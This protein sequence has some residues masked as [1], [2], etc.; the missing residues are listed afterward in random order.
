MY[1]ENK[2][3]DIDGYEARIGWVSFS[4][5]GR[6]VYYRG[7]HLKRIRRGGVFGNYR[8]SE[9]EDEYWVSGVKQRG[10]NAHRFE[11]KQIHIDKDA[12]LAY[13]ALRAS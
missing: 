4:R 5:S 10:S 7:R 9:T 12:E 2:D 11:P 1:V 3:G 13:R 6:S 8:C